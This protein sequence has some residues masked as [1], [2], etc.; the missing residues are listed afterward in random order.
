MKLKSV[1]CRHMYNTLRLVYNT[2]R[3][4]HNTL[5]LFTKRILNSGPCLH[6]KIHL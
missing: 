5:H 6:F 4:C 1:F 2:L 3:R